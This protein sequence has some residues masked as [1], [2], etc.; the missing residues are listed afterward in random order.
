MQLVTAGAADCTCAIGYC[1]RMVN[2]LSLASARAHS[3]TLNRT[4]W[5][6]RTKTS[7]MG[8]ADVGV[9]P[10]YMCGSGSGVATEGRMQIPRPPAGSM[11]IVALANPWANRKWLPGYSAP[12]IFA[13]RLGPPC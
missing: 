4:L 6:Q 2:A 1:E 10:V 3:E 13:I 11:R 7:F 8:G 5:Y 9:K 12:A